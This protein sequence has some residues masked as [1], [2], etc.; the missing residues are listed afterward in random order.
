MPVNLRSARGDCKL[1]AMQGERL[2]GK[3]DCRKKAIRLAAS[4]LAPIDTVRRTRD[5][6]PS[7]GGMAESAWERA[8][9]V[10]NHR[11]SPFIGSS[12]AFTEVLSLIEKLSKC[13]APVLIEGETGTGKE[14]AAR[15]IHYSGDRREA[16]FLPINCGAIPET[17]VE[18]E[19]FGHVRGAFTDAREGR[20][21]IVSQAEGGTLFLDEIEGIGPR[22]QVALLRF[23]QDF[24]YRP[25]GACLQRTANLRVIAAS[26]VILSELAGRGAFRRDLLFR[27]NVF[28][29]TMPPLRHRGG[30]V[31]LLADFFI[32]RFCRRYRK[33]R[34]QLQSS[35]VDLLAAYDWPG[36][37][38]ELENLLHRSVLLNDGAVLRLDSL[39]PSHGPGQRQMQGVGLTQSGFRQAKAQA[40]SAFERAYLV[41][42]LCRTRGNITE[43]ARLCGQ[44]RSRLNKLV[45][46][47]GLERD[48]FARSAQP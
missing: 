17:L 40:V 44:E 45:R 22:G 8:M 41:E 2:R 15:A 10:S 39:M 43:A 37:I 7:L 24:E 26:N 13:D 12:P 47:H 1:A 14:L 42:L 35:S 19:L 34:M 48:Q 20:R 5:T 38:R 25:V 21:G 27:L 4:G 28:C 32:E 30:D 33:D 29:L 36:N 23:L 16:P 9:A 11:D 3:D 31:L 6:G 18:S 46:K